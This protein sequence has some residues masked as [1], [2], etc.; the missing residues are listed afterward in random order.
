M[1]SGE[2]RRLTESKFRNKLCS[3][4]VL[5][6]QTALPSIF[7]ERSGLVLILPKVKFVN[8]VEC[9]DTLMSGEFDCKFQGVKNYFANT[10][11]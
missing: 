3:G 2:T 4:L 10:N 6:T 8:V 1:D 7:T 11:A 5:C 9:W